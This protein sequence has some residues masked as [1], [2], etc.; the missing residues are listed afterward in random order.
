MK[1]T[2]KLVLALTLGL[3]VAGCSSES[4]PAVASSSSDKPVQSAKTSSVKKALPVGEIISTKTNNPNIAYKMAN[5]RVKFYR[6]LREFGTKGGVY[7]DYI[8]EKGD[9]IGID[10]II[11]TTKGVYYHVVRYTVS[12]AHG[13]EGKKKPDSLGYVGGQALR[14]FKTIKSEW[15]YAHKQPYYVA[16]P[17][18]HRIWNR[19]AYTEAYTYITH[20]F[21]RLTTQQL[22]ATKELITHKN[23]HYVY[24]ETAKGRKLGWVYKARHTLIA[25]KYR[26]P[27]E[28]LLK[29]K[30]H[31]HL[32]TKVQSKK[33]TKNRVGVNDSLSLQ[34]R[35]YLVKNRKNQIVRVLIISMDNRPIKIYFRNGR[36]VKVKTYKYRRTLWRSTTNKKKL[37]SKYLV[38]HV[39]SYLSVD[40]TRSLFYSIKNKKLV[41]VETLGFDGYGYVVVYRNGHVKFVTGGEGDSITYSIN[42]YK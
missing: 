21:D 7:A 15:T 8:S 40:A 27:G 16:D 38:Q 9:T 34:Q 30:K 26:D 11:T 33:S 36:A 37:R 42:D 28:Q 3:F 1:N 22:Y 20:V 29:L 41:R 4:K 23:L 12:E 10:K 13:F 6:S 31:E 18:S 35:A 32:V 24:L 25:G 17:N 2:S 19:P 39:G 14:P 5:K